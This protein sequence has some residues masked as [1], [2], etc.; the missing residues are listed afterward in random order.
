MNQD[1]KGK[2]ELGKC[3]TV[4]T[5]RNPYKLPPNTT[6]RPC[7]RDAVGTY[8]G[9]P[10][11]KMHLEMYQRQL[12]RAQQRQIWRKQRDERLQ[13]IREEIGEEAYQRALA[14]NK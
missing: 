11:C 1:E 9:R 7:G 14:R 8:C 3:D 10:V 5:M 2:G 12:A 13:G 6:D 4:V